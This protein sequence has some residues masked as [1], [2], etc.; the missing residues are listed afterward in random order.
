MG[1]SALSSRRVAPAGAP[2][3]RTTRK[4]A[5]PSVTNSVASV[6]GLAPP[7]LR[8]CSA[9]STPPPTIPAATSAARTNSAGD[10]PRALR[11]DGRPAIEISS[12]APALAG[13]RCV[14]V[15]CEDVA[16]GVSTVHKGCPVV[17]AGE[18][19]ITDGAIGVDNGATGG[20]TGVD[21]GAITDGATGVDSGATGGATG[22]DNG[23][24]G[25]ATG[26][27]T[28]SPPGT[29]GHGTFTIVLLALATFTGPAGRALGALGD[30]A[31]ALGASPVC[32][33]VGNCIPTIVRFALL[34][35]AGVVGRLCVGTPVDTPAGA[36]ATG[37]EACVGPPPCVG[38]DALASKADGGSATPI[39]VRACAPGPA[40]CAVPTGVAAVCASCAGAD[41][42]PAGLGADGVEE[43][44]SK[45]RPQEPQK[46]PSLGSGLPH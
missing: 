8:C 28:G 41:G 34:T 39:I 4:L 33:A 30:G 15:R 17:T 7:G 46:R 29:V 5:P 20:A 14:V 38:A 22:V 6:S 2:G 45:G 12:S 31:F 37:F 1:A 43:A 23:A 11:G 35:L 16:A 32:N 18:G 24:T 26:T 9:R 36:C 19:A 27:V 25:G 13:A 40:V 10:R 21:N 3:T 44:P 42:A